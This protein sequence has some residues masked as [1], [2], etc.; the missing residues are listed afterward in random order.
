MI[1][2]A[3]DIKATDSIRAIRHFTSLDD[4]GYGQRTDY[5]GGK[6]KEEVEAFY[7]YAANAVARYLATGDTSHV[8]KCIAG[9]LNVGRYRSFIRIA[10]SVVA[11]KFNKAN[12]ALV[13]KIDASKKA[14]LV[15]T[16]EKSGLERWELLL[17]D[18][19]A[20]ET[21]HQKVKPAKAWDEDAAI[22]RFVKAAV[23]NN[24][25]TAAMLKKVTQAF[26]EQAA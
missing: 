18:N 13:G 16:D 5:Y 15:A 8:N 9:A 7:A 6:G 26:E 25:D 22:V 20:M 19:I 2:A 14:K 10:K 21:Q 12:K 3:K 11:H 4:T 17:K 1:K 23:D 24:V